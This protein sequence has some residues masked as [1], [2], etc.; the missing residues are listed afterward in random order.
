[1]RTLDET[2]T[3]FVANAKASFV[4]TTTRRSYPAKASTLQLAAHLGL[5]EATAALLTVIGDPTTVPD[6]AGRDVV[7]A[8]RATI[9]DPNPDALRALAAGIDAVFEWAIVLQMRG[10]SST[11]RLDAMSALGW[12]GKATLYVAAGDV[13]RAN[14]AGRNMLDAVTR[15]VILTGHSRDDLARLTSDLSG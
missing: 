1:M 2:W 8:I 10:Q 6:A 9:A 11:L 15:V 4:V 13:E 7:A 3:R 14:D 5:V 12:A